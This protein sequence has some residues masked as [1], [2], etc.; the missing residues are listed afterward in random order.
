L[1]VLF[2]LPLLLA[3]G[4]AS[5]SDQLD[6]VPE[7][8]VIEDPDDDVIGGWSPPDPDLLPS[9]EPQPVW[10]TDAWSSAAATEEPV[11]FWQ[12]VFSDLLTCKADDE[13]SREVAEALLDLLK[14]PD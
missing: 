4:C 7:A 9:L 13:T 8:P 1:S 11:Q 3:V 5:T 12:A 10:L 2:L 14:P 6:P